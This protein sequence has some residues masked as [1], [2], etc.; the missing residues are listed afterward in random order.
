MSPIKR[1]FVQYVW[2]HKISF[3]AGTFCL[4]LTNFFTVNIPQQIGLAID[5]LNDGL[6]LPNVIAIA[7]M[8]VGIII[9][10]T[11]S[12]VL[13]FNPGR[14]VEF[15][16]RQ[17]L[18][19]HLLLL[20]PKFY[21]SYVRGDII[22]RASNDITWTRI[23]VGFGGLQI[24]NVVF[25]MGLAGW[26][27]FEISKD[28][29]VAAVIPISI[30]FLIV[31]VIIRKLYPL[32]KRNQEELAKISEHVLESFQGVA[33]IQGFVAEPVFEKDFAKKNKDWFDTGMSV[34]ILRSLFSPLIG[35]AGGS[36][37]LAIIWVGAPLA[38]SDDLTVGD[39][40]A[41]IALVATLIPYM[42]SIGW[43]LSVW[44]RGR[45]SLERIFEIMDNDPDLP[46]GKNP[47]KYKG[48]VGPSFRFENLTF[49]YPDD[50]DT[51]VLKNITLKIPSGS[52]V[53]IFG[54]TGS[55]KS[56]L[57]SLLARSQTAEPD[58]LYVNEAQLRD[59][60]IFQWRRHLSI[61]PQRPFLFSDTIRANIAMDDSPPSDLIDKAVSLAA[62]NQDLLSMPEGLE[63]VV[64]ERGIMLSGGQRQRVALARALYRTGDLILLDDIL[65]AVD[66]ENEAILVST[67][68]RLETE[69]GK[70]TCVIVSNRISAFRHT[71]IIFVLESGRLI[72]QGSHRELVN[73][74]GPYREAW[75]A[76]QEEK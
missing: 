21:S 24:V 23:M 52:S 50:P 67:L 10:R 41:F 73:Q 64:G 75:Y 62:L 53:G 39:L 4:F 65:S 11:L 58:Q 27:M 19:Q 22:S 60:D 56:T 14:D 54:R 15:H 6:A 3:I 5:H 47:K 71:D 38:I 68:D 69:N 20:Q 70:P 36:A 43:M 17:D 72:S 76:Q 2:P 29:T 9:V 46:E 61:A 8:G 45:A 59:L 74:D 25:A 13:F 63:T 35:L 44:Q 37:L 18:F 26:K 1:L 16:I 33:T 7:L 28:L 49:A 40:A 30:G 34:A 51:P 66:H 48:G 57:L 31:N 42:R 55:G 32:L 12:R